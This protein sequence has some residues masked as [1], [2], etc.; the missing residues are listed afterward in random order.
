MHKL[1][2]EIIRGRKLFFLSPVILKHQTDP[3]WG[4]GSMQHLRV[5][6]FFDFKHVLKGNTMD[7]L[8]KYS[9]LLIREG[10]QDEIFWDTTHPDPMIVN[11]SP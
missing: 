6:S 2:F 10:D 11:L 3:N 7:L 8:A 5:S 9:K 1:H 4:P